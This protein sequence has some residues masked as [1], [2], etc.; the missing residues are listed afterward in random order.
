MAFLDLGGGTEVA[1]A[2]AKNGIAKYI[3]TLWRR[4]QRLG[5]RGLDQYNAETTK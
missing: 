3:N 4:Q 1:Y 5:F 2:A